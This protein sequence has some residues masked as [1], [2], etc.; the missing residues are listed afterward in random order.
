[1]LRSLK[2]SALHARAIAL[3][4]AGW[5]LSAIG[6]A[7]DPPRGRSTVRAWV[8]RPTSHSPQTNIFPLPTPSS[9]SSDSSYST[10]PAAENFHSSSPSS[11]SATSTTSPAPG[12]LRRY[13]PEKPQL[14]PYAK[15][16]I[17][18][19]APIAKRYRAGMTDYSDAAQANMELTIVCRSSYTSGVSITELADAAGVSYNAMKRR[20]SQ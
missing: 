17:A 19:L 7:L 1:M 8:T 16:R 15:N 10:L 14:T 6:E 4:N 2:G 18:H 20:V 11:T 5:S 3:H 13:D 9:D 12:A